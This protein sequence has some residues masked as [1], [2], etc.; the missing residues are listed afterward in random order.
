MA[1]VDIDLYGREN[2]DGTPKVYQ[3]DD[4][5]YNAILLW[6]SSSRGDF[7]YKPREGGPLS[8]L[9]FKPLISNTEAYV[10]KLRESFLN[11]F[12]AY[13]QIKAIAII[14]DRS[15]YKWKV[16]LAVAS[17]ITGAPLEIQVET[18][19]LRPTLDQPSTSIS[20]TYTEAQLFEWVSKTKETYTTERLLYKADFNQWYWGKYLLVNLVD[21]DPYF[22]D[23]LTLINT[24]L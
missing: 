14:P 9:L 3:S 11:A 23:I 15:R 21:T 22:L 12:G 18:P 19:S 24:G 17:K 8:M 4:A 20:I 1:I 10:F 7:L 5:L 6:L 2:T 13:A 16:V